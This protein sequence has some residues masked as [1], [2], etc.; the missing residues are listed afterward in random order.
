MMP[1]L[2][3]LDTSQ[4]QGG[5]SWWQT[6]G[7]LLAVFGLLFLTLKFLGK[8]NSGRTGSNQAAIL[9]VWN[10]GPKREIQVLKL[11]EEVHYIYRHDGAMVPLKMQDL[12]DWN[13]ELAEIGEAKAQSPEGWK[14]FFPGGFSLS[15]AGP[16]T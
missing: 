11:G 16:T 2:A 10:L 8:V 6:M 12:A 4:F 3:E 7:G 14:K 1:M 9:T 15:A 5:M 13:R